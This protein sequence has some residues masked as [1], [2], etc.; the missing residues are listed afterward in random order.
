MKSWIKK[1][2][3]W[4]KAHP[5]EPPW[6]EEAVVYSVGEKEKVV[7]LWLSQFK[8]A[9]DELCI[10]DYKW[11]IR[12]L[13][14]NIYDHV[15]E[16]SLGGRV[17]VLEAISRVNGIC[18]QY[19]P[20]RHKKY[21]QPEF[22][23]AWGV[24]QLLAM[25]SVID[26]LK[27]YKD[28]ELKD[29][30]FWQFAD[31]IPLMDYTKE[32][33]GSQFFVEIVHRNRNGSTVLSTVATNIMPNE[34]KVCFGATLHLGIQYMLMGKDPNH[35]CF[36]R[37][38]SIDSRS[39]DKAFEYKSYLELYDEWKGYQMVVADLKAELLTANEAAAKKNERHKKESDD[40]RR[41]IEKLKEELTLLK[42]EKSS[43][44]KRGGKPKNDEGAKSVNVPKVKKVV[45][46]EIP[47]SEPANEVKVVETEATEIDEIE[48]VSVPNVEAEVL[49]SKA[50]EVV[51]RDES[52]NEVKSKKDELEN[53]NKV[54]LKGAKTA[55]S[56]VEEDSS[57]AEALKPTLQSYNMQ[58]IKASEV[59][60][61]QKPSDEQFETSYK[62]LKLYLERFQLEGED[63]EGL[64]EKFKAGKS[65]RAFMEF[66]KKAFPLVNE[67][68]NK[69]VKGI[70]CK[71]IAEAGM[72]V[73]CVNNTIAF[74]AMSVPRLQIWKQV[75]PL[76]TKVLYSFPDEKLVM[77][78]DRKIFV[79]A[80]MVFMAEE[81][82]FKQ[83]LSEDSELRRVSMDQGMFQVCF[84]YS[85]TIRHYRFCGFKNEYPDM[86][87]VM[88]KNYK[89]LDLHECKKN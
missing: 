72:D 65:D 11:I 18:K 29:E 64:L 77:K 50:D 37:W 43:S 34:M 17:I 15:G 60:I 21:N 2:S 74:R 47:K 26:R 86:S 42:E 68:F 81:L 40:F 49:S 79:R 84:A 22:K 67:G 19:V 62:Y 63:L 16:L 66:K 51:H 71:K 14:E 1:L 20:H 44:S 75:Q 89:G 85:K 8:P 9:F 36:S 52:E 57:K 5:S 32:R 27:V 88:A 10:P 30:D 54:D 28:K 56:S 76:I 12:E 55:E 58:G 82:F 3:L 33:G 73:A 41:A 39:I 53:K 80:G 45:E 35:E 59:S 38:E 6:D 48:I 7:D 23:T 13:F 70:F 87:P 46:K 31:G 24:Y 4:K 25:I 69:W 83:V 61:L 78:K